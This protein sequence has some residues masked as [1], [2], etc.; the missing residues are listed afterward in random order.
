M[1]IDILNLLLI[2]ATERN[3]GKTELACRLIKK[4]SVSNT[5]VG[6]KIT[7]IKEKD[8]KC[9]RGG[10]GCGVCTSLIGNYSITQEE[11]PDR[12]KDT[13]KMLKAGAKSVFWLRVLESYLYEGIQKMF[14]EIHRKCAGELCFICES[15]SARNA[16]RPGLFLVL[17]KNKSTYMKESCRKVIDES[18]RIINF[19]NGYDIALEQI[20]FDSGEWHFKE[21]ATAI[22]LAGG[23]GRRIGKSK[24]FLK[25]GDVPFIE[26][27]LSKL[28]NNFKEIIIS[29]NKPDVYSKY[30]CK[31]ASDLETGQGPLMGIYSALLVSANDTNFV[32]ACDIPEIDILFVKKTAKIC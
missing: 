3:V 32:V 29:S 12:D 31:I 25:K 23:E 8:G 7:V 17:R 13:S 28:K 2:G 10:I 21:N 6:I 22:V 16:I 4:H 27:T 19:D 14:D 24:P 26:A 18:D 9:P 11:N 1:Q 30:C 5:V 20:I 15:N